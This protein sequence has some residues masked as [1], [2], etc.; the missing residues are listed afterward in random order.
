ME[1]ILEV[2]EVRLAIL[3]SFPLQLHISARGTVPTGGWS[4]PR[5]KPHVNVQA[6]PDGIYGFDFVA[7][8]PEGIVAQVV[9]PIEITDVWENLPED[10][11]GVRI[12]AAQNTKA[13]LLNTVQPDRQP[14]RYTFGDDEGARR[15]VFFPEMLGRLNEGESLA[16]SQFEYHGPEGQFI[17]HGDEISQEQTVLGT[18]ISVVLR[19]NADAGGVDFAL[20]LP[21]VKL[22]GK[23]HQ[24][25]DTVGIKIRSK[26]RRMQPAGAELTYEVVK[27]KGVAEDIPVL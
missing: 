4:N 16:G 22:E 15:I 27:L 7:D 20:A 10:V 13:A 26:G 24:E 12:H 1:K 9:S 25:F 5:L 11:K 18:L 3:E 14:N 6:P 21:P 19:P 2:T 23:A 17:F 8:P